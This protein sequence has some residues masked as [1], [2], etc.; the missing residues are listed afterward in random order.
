MS[1]GGRARTPK[2]VSTP[3]QEI[4][5]RILRDLT[6]RQGLKGEWHS[7]PHDIQEEILSTWRG[8]VRDVCD[9]RFPG[10]IHPGV[11]IS[12]YH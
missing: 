1:H 3:D 7:I 10:G 8:I 11:A 6:D 9:E 5:D 12:A 2:V 4:V